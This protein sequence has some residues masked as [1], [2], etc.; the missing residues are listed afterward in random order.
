MTDRAARVL[1]SMA[2]CSQAEAV[3]VIWFANV[4]MYVCR[5]EGSEL[6]ERILI[7]CSFIPFL[8]FFFPPVFMGLN[9]RGKNMA[10]QVAAN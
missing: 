3:A 6:F 4:C 8:F 5:S 9:S 10:N 2:H 1:E 7:G